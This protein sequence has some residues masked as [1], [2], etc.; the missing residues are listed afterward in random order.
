[1]E[2]EEGEEEGGGWNHGRRGDLGFGVLIG[3]VGSHERE[4]EGF[5]F[6]MTRL[7]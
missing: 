5:N 1:M 3:A 2:L 6:G 7:G 4:R